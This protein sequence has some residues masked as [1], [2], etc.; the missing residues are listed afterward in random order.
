MEILKSDR[1]VEFDAQVGR[2]K[3]AEFFYIEDMVYDGKLAL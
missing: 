3:F 1:R 2:L